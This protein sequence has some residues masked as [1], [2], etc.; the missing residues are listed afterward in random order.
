MNK[1]NIIF[2]AGLT[3][4]SAAVIKY[5]IH[6]KPVKDDKQASYNGFKLINLKRKIL[7]ITPHPDDAE[8]FA[9]ALIKQIGSINKNVYMLDVTDGEKGTNIKH[10][11]SIRQNEQVMAAEKLGVNKPCFLHLPD[12]HL[13]KVKNLEEKIEPYI[14]QIDPDVI[15]TFDSIYPWR[16]IKHPDHIAVGNAVTNILK[17]RK[18]KATVIIYYATRKP[19]ITVDISSS[20]KEKVDIIKIHKSQLRFGTLPYKYILK[21]YAALCAANSPL[22]YAEV[23]RAAI[24]GFGVVLPY[25]FK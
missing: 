13:D 17:R 8:F 6:I 15:V 16:L 21:W 25:N 19:N 23:Y 7:V 22:C 1:K 14:K 4:V 5:K 24:A 18:D 3:A 2:A 12:M 11:A 20:L 9:G 10:L